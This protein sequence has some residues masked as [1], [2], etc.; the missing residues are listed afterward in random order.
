IEQWKALYRGYYP[1]WHDI[2]YHTIEGPKT[3]RMDSLNMAKTSAAE[4]ASLVFNEKCEIYIGDNENETAEIIF[5]V[6]KRNKFNKKFQDYLEFMYA[7]GGMI[8]KLYDENE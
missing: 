3:R 6:F 7:I 4:M 5:D 1:D 8:A 2:T